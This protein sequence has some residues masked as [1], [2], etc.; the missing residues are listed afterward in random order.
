MAVNNSTFV[1]CSHDVFLNLS[2][3]KV[4]QTYLLTPTEE[5]FFTWILPTVLITC[6]L[7]N[8]AFIFIF[9]SVKSMR[10]VTNN[11]LFHVAISDILFV[12]LAVAAI[13]YSS[14]RSPVRNDVAYRSFVGC[15]LVYHIAMTTY[16]VSLILITSVT[17][18]R[19]YAI[20]KPL[21]HR[22]VA[23]KLRTNKIIVA[24][25]LLGIFFGAWVA[26]RYAGFLP[27]C[28]QWPDS[29]EFQHLPTTIYYCVVV[30]PD[31]YIF[32]EITQT[33]PLFLAMF[34]NIY[35]YSSII[36]ALSQRLISSKRI[37]DVTNVAQQQ[38]S[39]RVRNQVARLLIINGTLFFLCQTPYRITSMHNMMVHLGGAGIFT[40]EQYGAMLVIGRCLILINSCANPFIYVTTSSFYR[41][42]FLKAFECHLNCTNSEHSRTSTV[43]GKIQAVYV[44]P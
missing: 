23:G 7:G 11:Y 32:S 20:C 21:K 34:V 4:A 29:E 8:S 12:T 24:S 3:I 15:M 39:Q 1:E 14:N 30:H 2:D 35:M 37:D 38:Q 33:A 27:Q 28:V 43:S 25:W 10:T 42:A 40:T 16:F 44:K 31:I 19:Y 26:P 6:L 13:L 18:E 9:I 17:I 22:I 36:K 5:L 41:E